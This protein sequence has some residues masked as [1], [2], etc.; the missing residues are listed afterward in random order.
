[1][2]GKIR[3]GLAFCAALTAAAWSN[4]SERVLFKK[5]CATAAVRGRLT[6]PD[7]SGRDYLL[8]GKAGERLRV[9]LFTDFPQVYY[10]VLPPGERPP[11]A[12]T[13]ITGDREWSG[14]L[15]VDGEYRVRV[16]LSRRASLGAIAASYKMK[17]WLPSREKI[18]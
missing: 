7:R 14:V 18:E 8:E 16:Y 5:G 15:P 17:L 13:S 2:A 11:L 6:G 12:N 3:I 9:E 4:P 10:N 1:V